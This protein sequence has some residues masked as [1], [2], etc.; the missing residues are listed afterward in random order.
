MA[1][2][3][4]RNA[5][6]PFEALPERDEVLRRA[7]NV[8]NATAAER[9]CLAAAGVRRVEPGGAPHGCRPGYP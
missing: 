8:S 6:D 4:L 3:E 2:G 1:A 7:L 5:S 9:R